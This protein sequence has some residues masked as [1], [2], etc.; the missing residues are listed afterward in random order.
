MTVRVR[1][2]AKNSGASVFGCPFLCG[3]Y[4]EFVEGFLLGMQKK[5]KK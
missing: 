5:E 4:P 1:W 2:P 3:F